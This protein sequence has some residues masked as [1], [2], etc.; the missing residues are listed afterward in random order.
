RT[1]LLANF[2]I[3]TTLSFS[4]HLS[5]TRFCKPIPSTIRSTAVPPLGYSY[6][7]LAA[8]INLNGGKDLHLKCCCPSFSSINHCFPS[9]HLPT[10]S[11][12]DSGNSW[13][14]AVNGIASP[15]CIPGTAGQPPRCASPQRVIEKE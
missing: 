11:F 13:S 1:S 14:R 3:S 2:H 6:T 7:G 5:L 10:H 4:F 8:S 9:P 15:T 12:Q